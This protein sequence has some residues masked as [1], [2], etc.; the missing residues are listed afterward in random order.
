MYKSKQFN[1]GKIIRW[2][3]I[4]WLYTF[5]CFISCKKIA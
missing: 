4:F 3:L 1:I 5:F 2:I